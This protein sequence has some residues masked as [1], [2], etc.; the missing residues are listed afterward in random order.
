MH[1]AARTIAL[2]ELVALGTMLVIA[3]AVSSVR[4]ATSHHSLCVIG[5]QCPPPCTVLTKHCHPN[6]I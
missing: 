4:G 2:I 1:T 3:V 5:K 6:G